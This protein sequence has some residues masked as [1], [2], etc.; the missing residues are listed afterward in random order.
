MT[1]SWSNHTR[2]VICDCGCASGSERELKKFKI[3][4]EKKRIFLTFDDCVLGRAGDRPDDD[5]RVQR[6]AG[7]QRRVRRPGDFVYARVVESPFLVVSKLKE[8][9]C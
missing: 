2:P 6:S 3:S 8:F 5:C 9:P 4:L 1:V 7:D